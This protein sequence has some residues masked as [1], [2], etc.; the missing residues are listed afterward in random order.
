[1]WG[2]G[3]RMLFSG[4]C[5]QVAILVLVQLQIFKKRNF[6]NM[7]G[8]KPILTKPFKKVGQLIYFLKKMSGSVT[9]IE[10]AKMAFLGKVKNE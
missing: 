8:Y 7:H 3:R 10:S 1:M 5:A 6:Y 2:E 9:Q 4:E